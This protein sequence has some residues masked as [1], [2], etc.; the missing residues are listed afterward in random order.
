[1]AYSK[2]TWVNDDPSKPLSAGRMTHLEDGLFIAAAT[3]D[4]AAGGVTTLNTLVNS[5]RLSETELAN[6]IVDQ[7]VSARNGHK[8]VFLAGVIR[9]D[10]AEWDVLPIGT[11]HRPVNID[12]VETLTDGD[13]VNGYIQINY[14]SLGA[15]T[16]V[17]FLAVPDET[18]ASHGFIMGTSVTETSTAIRI[19]QSARAA[20]DY[21]YY[22]GT[23]WVSQDGVFTT[24]AF[25]S[26][27]GKLALTHG[28]LAIPEAAQYAVSIAPRTNKYVFHV[29]ESSSPFASN[30]IDIQIR[31]NTPEIEGYVSYNGTDWV[32]PAAFTAASFS[33]GVLTLTHA[34]IP[35]ADAQKVVLTGRGA[36]TPKVSTASSPTTSTQVKVE[37]YDASGALVTVPDTSCRAYIRRGG[38]TRPLVT[39]PTTDMKFTVTH[40]GGVRRVHPADV[41]TAL[42]P[43]SN[44]WLF[45]VMEM[46]D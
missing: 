1:M 43:S 19:S 30:R 18:L 31:D 16:T 36:Y 39:A 29:A 46:P 41:T 8:N 40:G 5:G 35:S 37:F 20:S 10:G 11:N 27:T 17:A 9:N 42:Y 44:I 2:Q 15:N 24:I 32:L 21:V 25:D 26:A 7:A 45:G 4:S 23:N 34:S 3:A 6:T 12:S 22:D 33:A 28:A 13:G 38:S 14:A